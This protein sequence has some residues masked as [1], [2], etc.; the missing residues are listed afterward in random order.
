MMRWRRSLV[1]VCLT[2]GLA[3]G[4]R[5]AER[6]PAAP[7]AEPAPESGMPGAAT[8]PPA[9]AP[10]EGESESKSEVSAD[11][12]KDDDAL[13]R[14][15]TD[16]ERAQG[17]L[18]LALGPSPQTQS[19]PTGASAGAPAPA[20]AE[21]KRS[22]ANEAPRDEAAKPDKKAAETSCQTACRAF[23]SLGRAASSICRLT[24]AEDGRCSH[25]K[26][27]VTQAERRVSSCGCKSE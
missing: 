5:Q 15:Q 14:A 7:S 23:Q 16:L 6:A 13:S 25:A 24:G 19:A 2:L 12:G 10:L 27:V 4:S 21:P 20:A 17:E 3:C 8:P 18:E 11:S 26:S 22:R 1:L 9:P